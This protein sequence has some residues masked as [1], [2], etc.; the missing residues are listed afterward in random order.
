MNIKLFYIICYIVS[1]FLLLISIKKIYK[2][3]KLWLLKTILIFI[4][5][6]FMVYSINYNNVDIDKYILPI[7]LYVNIF[8]LIP[9][10]ISNHH[11]LINLLPLI[12]IIYILFIYNIKDFAIN[13]GILVNPNKYWI[14]LY[15]SV[16]LL[17]FLMSNSSNIHYI[18]KYGLIILLFYP[19]LFPINE[20]F[21]HRIFSLCLAVPLSWILIH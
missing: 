1:I 21:L 18:S 12:G 5:G 9:L 11:N 6:A 14:Y 8:L 13:K 4:T 10:S 17:F 7:L 20:Y 2:T 15:I 3:D 19:L 16:L